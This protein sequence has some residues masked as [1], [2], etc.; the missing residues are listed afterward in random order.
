VLTCAGEAF[1]SRVAASLLHA[2]GMPELVTNSP[3]DYEALALKLARDPAALAAVK[4][5]LA[6]NR[7][8]SPL[9]D[10]EKFSVNIEAAYEQMWQRHQRGE[11]PAGFAVAG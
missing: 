7:A 11:Q 6:A 2:V 5:K 9:F 10:T 8:T 1:A 4:S 3:V